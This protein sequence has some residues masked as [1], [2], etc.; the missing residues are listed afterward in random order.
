M[1]R[2]MRSVEREPDGAW[3]IAPGHLEKAEAF[4]ARQLRD[5]PVTVE[6][7]SPMPLDR[8]P[9]AEAATWLDRDLV[10]GNPVAV[11]DAGFGREVLAAQA[12]R[13]QWLVAEGHAEVKD[14]RTVYRRG[15]LAALQRRELLR[16]VGQL[17]EDLGVPFVEARAG[18]RI[19]GIYRR[20]V[21]TMSGR[22]ALIEKAR[23]FTLVPWRSVLERQI[24][25]PVGG[26]VREGGISWT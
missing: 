26:I 17:A 25:K 18:E 16:I 12:A 2:I 15:A 7:L 22:M 20:H 24:G 6:T 23:E 13:R 1:R 19:E 11:R 3:I 8:L 14:G 4:E 21:E 10:A 9:G 5:R